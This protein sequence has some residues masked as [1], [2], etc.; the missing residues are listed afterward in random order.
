[1]HDYILHI[2]FHCARN[3]RTLIEH[4]GNVTNLASM[5]TFP[6]SYRKNR[7]FK[8]EHLSLIKYI[9][10][11]IRNM[12][13]YFKTKPKTKSHNPYK[14]PVLRNMF[15]VRIFLIGT[16]WPQTLELPKGLK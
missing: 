8:N 14:L 16:R 6:T 12:V 4:Y 3:M 13:T 1:M 11:Y 2:D 7:I 15:A 10:L 5:L 9:G